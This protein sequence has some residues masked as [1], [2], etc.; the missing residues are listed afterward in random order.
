MSQP[1]LSWDASSRPHFD[2]V[3]CSLRQARDLC[4]PSRSLFCVGVGRRDGAE[5]SEPE[6]VALFATAAKPSAVMMTG[7]RLL[8]SSEQMKLVLLLGAIAGSRSRGYRCVMVRPPFIQP[9][10][11]TSLLEAGF[12]FSKPERCYLYCDDRPFVVDPH[13]QAVY[14]RGAR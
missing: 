8:T 3:P 11:A 9:L 2:I 10:G 5:S 1:T 7:C 4:G 6:A 12:V 13:G 14:P